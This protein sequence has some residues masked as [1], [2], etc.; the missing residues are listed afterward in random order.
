M[1]IPSFISYG[2]NVFSFFLSK[3][4]AQ[5]SKITLGGYDLNSYA[6]EGKQKESDV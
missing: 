6:K 1:V 5:T 4:P 3:D 2:E